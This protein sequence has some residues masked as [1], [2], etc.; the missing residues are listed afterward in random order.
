MLPRSKVI[1]LGR[2]RVVPT[3]LAGTDFEEYSYI[4]KIKN[5]FG[6]SLIAYWPLNETSGT[7]AYDVSGNS[8][9]GVYTSPILTN[10]AGPVKTKTRA[11]YFDGANNCIN[12]YSTSLNAAF[13]NQEGTFVMFID[14]TLAALTDGLL[15][16]FGL[17]R[18]DGT[19]KVQFNKSALNNTYSL[20]YTA[21]GVAKE[22][23]VS[24]SGTTMWT[25]MALTWSKS[26]DRVIGY[27]RGLQYGPALTGLGVWAGPLSNTRTLLGANDLTPTFVHLGWMAHVFL[28][29]REATTLEMVYVNGWAI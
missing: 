8:R 11:P 22:V 28:L 1:P 21:G 9:N 6:A 2:T 19:N 23:L 7:V 13:N 14:R 29:N 10:L 4:Q 25:N 24:G 18:A 27:E 26:K 20:T 3:R 17:V 5:L 15:R 16:Y 12:I